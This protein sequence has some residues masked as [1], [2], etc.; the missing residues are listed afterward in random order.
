MRTDEKTVRWGLLG[1][2]KIL[3]RWMKGAL[4]AQNTE[5]Y[6]V[7]SRTRQTAEHMAGKWHIPRVMSYDE[8]IM[9]PDIDVV[10]IPVPH[11]EHKDLALRAMR[12]GKHVLVEKPACVTAADFEE[13]T[14]CAVQ[15]RVFLME[16][17]WTRFFP[18]IAFTLE[19]IKNGM[20]GDVRMLQ[21]GFSFR[22]EDTYQGRLTNPA[23]A[24][25]GLLDV[26]VYPLHLAHMVFGRAPVTVQGVC[27]RDTDGMHLQVDEQAAFTALYDHGEIAMCNSGIRTETED[28]AYIY[29]T[30]GYMVLPVFW[31]ARHV[32][33]HKGGE[34][35]QF[36]FPVPGGEETDAANGDEGYQFEIDHV[37]ECIRNGLTESPLMPWSATVTVLAQCDSLRRDWGLA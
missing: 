11:T 25:G 26:G 5:I 29:G 31:K 18:A 14:A 10:Y 9:C 16:A 37:N 1:A 7:A 4:K 17:V 8:M 20:I 34:T 3:D 23:T 22:V 36:D 2:G 19:Q 33:L 6:A 12:A 13:L 15:N 27:A 32:I 30:E 35:R 28:T 24:G 21:A